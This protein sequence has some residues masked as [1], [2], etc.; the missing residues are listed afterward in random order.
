MRGR[1]TLVPYLLPCSS[2]P[3]G[4]RLEEGPFGGSTHHSLVHLGAAVP[5][6]ASLEPLGHA[7]RRPLGR[8]DPLLDLG[9]GKGHQ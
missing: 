2:S 1:H 6:Q 7:V 9:V 8:L 5:L 4:L 3:L